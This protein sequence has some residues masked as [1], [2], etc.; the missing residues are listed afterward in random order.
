MR[1]APTRRPP[2]GGARRRSGSAGCARRAT[3]TASP[4]SFPGLAVRAAWRARS[5]LAARR[6]RLRPLSP[7]GGRVPRARRGAA[8]AAS[9]W[10]EAVVRSRVERG[11]R[12]RRR[13]RARRAR[14]VP[15]RA[16][17]ARP[18]GAE[19][20]RGAARATRGP[21]TPTSRTSTPTTSPS[22]APGM[23]AATEWLN[24]L[25][26]GAR[27][28]SVRRREPVR[29]PLNVPAA[30]LLASR[31]RAPSTPRRRPSGRRCC[32]TLLAPSYPPGRGW[33]EPLERARARF[34]VEAEVN[35][36]DADHLRH[37]FPARVRRTSRCSRG[38]SPSTRLE[39]H[40]DWIVL[41]P[42]C[43]VP[44]A[45]GRDAHA[46][47]RRRRRAVGV[48]R[49]PT[50]WRA[51]STRR[52]ASSEGQDV[53]HAERAGRVAPARRS[54]PLARRAACSRWRIHRWW[55]VEIAALMVGVGA[56]ARRGA[57]R[58]AA[59]TTS[60]AGSR[61]RSGALELALVVGA[62]RGSSACTAPLGAG[63]RVLRR[64]LAAR[65]GARA[66]RASRCCGSRTQRTAASS[67]ARA[68][69]GRRRRP[70]SC[71][72]RAASAYATRAADRDAPAGVH[73]GRS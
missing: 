32:D 8:R 3:A 60:R 20:A 38:S 53:V 55:P 56:R 64:R 46:R 66:R 10:D 52:T 11:P 1:P 5:R 43:T 23:A 33:D 4:T 73:R 34:R 30:A 62:G 25:A 49:P 21:F 22:S 59:S 31:P 16:A 42:D 35:G 7:D 2:G 15:A 72:P 36:A 26:A 61:C 50:R 28:D 69:R 63:A 70:R 68:P 19:R 12:G 14:H 58:P 9:G 17:R 13:L 48:S 29:R 57:L 40:G 67:A 41:A 47:A 18:S 44:A 71:W 65:A 6:E 45:H 54:L 27:V 51:R 39:T 37:R 24:A